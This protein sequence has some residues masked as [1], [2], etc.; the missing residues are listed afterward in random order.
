LTSPPETI[1]SC[2]RRMRHTD[3]QPHSGRHPL[4][5]S[6]LHFVF[7][8]TQKRSDELMELDREGPF[9]KLVVV[10]GALH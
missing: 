7:G 8:R 3:F 5:L 10:H 6:R 9:L 2:D 1:P 4:R